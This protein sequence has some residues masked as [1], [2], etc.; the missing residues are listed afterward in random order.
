MTAEVFA[1]ASGLLLLA[2][3]RRLDLFDVD[4]R[5]LLTRHLL[6]LVGRGRSGENA[7][8]FLAGASN[9]ASTGAPP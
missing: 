5:H 8:A 4:A 1:Q 3:T 2:H 9:L 7:A 6:A